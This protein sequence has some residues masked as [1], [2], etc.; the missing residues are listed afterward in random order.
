LKL[1]YIQCSNYVITS[2]IGNITPTSYKCQV[3]RG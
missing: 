2:Y 1:Y 3:N